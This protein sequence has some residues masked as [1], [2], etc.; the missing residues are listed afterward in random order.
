MDFPARRPRAG[1]LL[2]TVKFT[3]QALAAA[4]GLQ[5]NLQRE[6]TSTSQCPL[7]PVPCENDPVS[8]NLDIPKGA[9]SSAVP[10]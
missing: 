6:L 9:H 5:R 3:V 7:T 1:E 4:G 2:S 8:R 10:R